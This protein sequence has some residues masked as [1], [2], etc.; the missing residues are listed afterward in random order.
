M[1]SDILAKI[2]KENDR[3]RKR[4]RNLPEDTLDILDGLIDR[5]AFMRVQLADM[6]MDILQNG[7]VEMFSQSDKVDPYEK[8]RPVVK[9]YT[10]LSRNYQSISK[11][12]DDKLPKADPVD[13][14]DGF[15]SFVA[16]RE[17]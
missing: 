10:A 6:E 4:Y 11:Q 7:R 15:D 14:D 16:A 17:D 3:L 8:E 9:Q 5:A 12:L 2:Q 13:K 1:D